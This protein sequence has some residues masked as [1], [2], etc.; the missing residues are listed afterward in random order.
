MVGIDTAA[1]DSVSIHPV[2]KKR[3]IVSPQT[4]YQRSIREQTAAA[5]SGHQ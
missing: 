5:R 3:A 2:L 1:I 4:N